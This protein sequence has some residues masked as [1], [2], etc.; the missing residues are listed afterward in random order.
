MSAKKHRVVLSEKQR[1]RLKRL[2]KRGKVHARTL[3]HARILL[4]ADENRPKGGLTDAQ[5]TELLDIS[6]P[7]VVRVRKRFVTQGLDEAIFDKPRSG[8]PPFFSGK[9]RAEITALACS[10]PPE[11]RNRWS[12]RLMADKLV[13]LGFADAIS[14]E[15]VGVILK[16]T[17][18]RR[19]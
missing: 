2:S 7:T 11:G 6:E 5:I 12:L 15:T 8:R 4:L 17:N 1:Q 13:E 16:K 18:C 14:Y 10:T 19:I 9:Q 3:N